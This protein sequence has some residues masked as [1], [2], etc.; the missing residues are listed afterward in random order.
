MKKE[1]K[2]E[3]IA[4]KILTE[5]DQ[6]ARSQFITS[7]IMEGYIYILDCLTNDSE[8]V[9]CWIAVPN[10]PVVLMETI[11]I[12]S[13]THNI[14]M[15]FLTNYTNK[16]PRKKKQILTIDQLQ[17]MLNQAIDQENYEEAAKIRDKIKRR[18]KNAGK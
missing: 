1:Q 11:N 7:S 5:F 6:N 12:I 3:D 9:D 8:C 13:E 16:R 15:D 14:R 4:P 10:H 17:E 18:K 2:I